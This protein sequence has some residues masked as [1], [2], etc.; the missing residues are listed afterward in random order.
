VNGYDCTPQIVFFWKKVSSVVKINGYPAV[1][2]KSA[3][4]CGLGGKI[5]IKDSSAPYVNISK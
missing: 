3:L 5:G 1:T 2:S 4:K